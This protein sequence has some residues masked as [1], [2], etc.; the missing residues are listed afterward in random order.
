M[1]NYNYIVGDVRSHDTGKQLLIPHIVNDQGVMGAGIAASLAKKWPDVRYNYLDWFNTNSPKAPAKLG[2]NQYVPVQPGIV[3]VNMVAQS[4]CS[5][6]N[7]F[8]PIRYQSLEECLLRIKDLLSKKSTDNIEVATGLIGSGLA[9]GKWFFITEIVRRVFNDVDIDW[10]WY[11][12]T[13][14]EKEQAEKDDWGNSAPPYPT[15]ESTF[16]REDK[17]FHA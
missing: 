2:R 16:S 14:E 6:Y 3:V 13:A 9:G 11:C 7:G 5:G 8:P 4:D 15:M 1:A 17:P 12:L 10:T